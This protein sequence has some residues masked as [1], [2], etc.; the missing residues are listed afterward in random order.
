MLNDFSTDFGLSLTKKMFVAWRASVKS[1]S[2]FLLERCHNGKIIALKDSEFIHPVWYENSKHPEFN[3]GV[4]SLGT[5]CLAVSILNEF[6]EESRDYAANA[7]SSL[8]SNMK[9]E[10]YYFT[11]DMVLDWME[12]L[13]R[14]PG[15]PIMSGNATFP[16]M[17]KLCSVLE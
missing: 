4:Y 9:K 10:S 2:H 15:L 16:R 13:N 12:Y 5:F 14:I 8:L 7:F 1:T 6:G 3:F 17:P 11:S